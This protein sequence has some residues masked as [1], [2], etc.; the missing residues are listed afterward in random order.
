MI[1]SSNNK[2]ASQFISLQNNHLFFGFS[3]S[4]LDPRYGYGNWSMWK[5]FLPMFS[6]RAFTILEDSYYT[7][8]YF[9]SLQIKHSPRFPIF[10]YNLFLPGQCSS[11]VFSFGQS[12]VPRTR[13]NVL[14][15]VRSRISKW[16]G[17]MIYNDLD[18]VFNTDIL[19]AHIQLVFHQNT[20]LKNHVAQL[21]ALHPI[22]MLFL[23]RWR[24][25]SAHYSSL[26]RSSWILRLFPS[27][28]FHRDKFNPVLFIFFKI[29]FSLP[30]WKSLIN[31][32]N[33]TEPR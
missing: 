24:N 8:L 15:T 26:S 2:S 31:K 23:P 29:I 16:N 9:F 25:F 6:M 21:G 17:T 32:L 28:L 27:I 5:G 33:S 14:D 12:P 13:H 19:L 22:I 30:T 11:W 18:P 20:F 3:C 10:S 7:L 1:V 4:S